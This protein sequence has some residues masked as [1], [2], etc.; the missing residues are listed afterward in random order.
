MTRRPH[1]RIWA[2]G[3]NTGISNNA[4]LRG[5]PLSVVVFAPT[6]VVGRWIESE[7]ER[8][9]EAMVQIARSVPQLVASLV[10]DPDPP[11]LLIIDIDAI[12]A[13][14]LFALH[15]IRPRGWFGSIVAIGHVPKA[16]RDS[17]GVDRVITPPFSQ[18]QLRDV[19]ASLR[20]PIV[21][22]PIEIIPN[23]MFDEDPPAEALPP[24]PRPA[25]GRLRIRKITP[26]MRSAAIGPIVKPSNR[27]E[28]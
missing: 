23:M 14:D 2:K 5:E 4:S 9:P 8:D 25:S 12:E 13:G 7:L 16:L 18:D 21:T 24:A 11:R 6:A 22:V 27:R 1:P 26:A 19:L 17:L 20:A 15:E 28:R 3:T 10:N